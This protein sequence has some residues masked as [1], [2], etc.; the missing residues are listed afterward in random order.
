MS[1]EK[2]REA[3]LTKQYPDGR[4]HFYLSNAEPDPEGRRVYCIVARNMSFNE[5]VPMT[6]NEYLLFSVARGED[7]TV[8]DWTET[9]NIQPYHL[10]SL[11]DGIYGAGNGKKWTYQRLMQLGTDQSI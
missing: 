4:E 9:F 2:F 11:S 3:G 6:H 1:L 7:F 10:D 8:E 5:L